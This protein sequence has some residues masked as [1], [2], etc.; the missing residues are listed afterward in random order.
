[1]VP[2]PTAPAPT[3]F[4]PFTPREPPS[5]CRPHAK[6]PTV[7]GA[8]ATLL[9]LAHDGGP[10]VPDLVSYPLSSFTP[11]PGASLTLCKQAKLVLPQGL[12][13]CCSSCPGR[14]SSR[15]CHGGSSSGLSARSPSQR[16]LPDPLLQLALSSSCLTSPPK[17]SL[18]CL[19]P[20]LGVRLSLHLELW[21]AEASTGPALA[22]MSPG[23]G[24]PQSGSRLCT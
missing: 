13:T 10:T 14:S 11:L 16:V 15:S 23:P 6:L 2:T 7:H 4:Q 12:C 9:T 3:L 24:R 22:L 8:R 5:V 19:A 18:G 21:T 1:M 20:G 17:A